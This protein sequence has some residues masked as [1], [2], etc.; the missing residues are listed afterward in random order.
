VVVRIRIRVFILLFLPVCL[1][2]TQFR[3]LLFLLVVIGNIR[4]DWFLDA[5][6][7]DTDV[8]YLGNQHAYY[9]DQQPRLLKQWRK[10]DFAS[11]YFVMSMQGNTPNTLANKTAAPIEDTIHWPLILNIPGEGFGDD[12]LQIYTNHKL[13]DD[14]DNALFDIVDALLAINGTCPLISGMSDGDIGDGDGNGQSI[15]PPT[16]EV[17][18]PSNL[19]VDPNSWNSNVYTFSPVWQPPMKQ[20]DTD[21]SNMDLNVDTTSSS[22]SDAGRGVAVTEEDR[23]RVE[24]CYDPTTKSVQLKVEFNNIKA[25]EMGATSELPWLSL[26]YRISDVCTMNP[27]DGS[28]SKI[29]MISSSQSPNSKSNAPAAYIGSLT[30]AAQTMSPSAFTSINESLWPLDETIGYSDVSVTAPMLSSSSSSGGSD[31][32]VAIERSSASTF[33]NPTSV[34]LSFKQEFDKV[35]EVMHLMYAIGMSAQLGIHMS[36]GCFDIIDFPTCPS[37]SGSGSGS[38]SSSSSG[39]D[40]IIPQRTNE[41]IDAWKETNTASSAVATTT[42]TTTVLSSSAFLFLSSTVMVVTSLSAFLFL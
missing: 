27:P 40:D 21:E 33:A 12:N 23:V 8:Q 30:A 24:S 4:P 9:A 7:D 20:L 36:R 39:D 16:L 6:G 18:I 37:P 35:P 14:D 34:T 38:G 2:L 15:G 19:E 17:Y 22:S 32:D 31:S 26:G 29:I 28:D 3:L 5:R 25:I 41:A 11:Q 1:Y 42:T 13:L 10:K